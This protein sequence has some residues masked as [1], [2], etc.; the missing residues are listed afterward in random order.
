MVSSSLAPVR[1]RSL[2]P[3]ARSA[4]SAGS[5]V[6]RSEIAPATPSGALE[7]VVPALDDH[8]AYEGPA[9]VTHSGGLQ[10]RDCA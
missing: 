10:R 4:G 9:W 3:A 8:R 1:R 7:A 6:E 5:R 2:A